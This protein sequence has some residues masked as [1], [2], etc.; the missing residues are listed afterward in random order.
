M[1]NVETYIVG[2]REMKPF[3]VFK[4]QFIYSNRRPLKSYKGEVLTS[5]IMDDHSSGSN[6]VYQNNA[7]HGIYSPVKQNQPWQN[8]R[9][10]KRTVLT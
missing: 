4:R 9:A 3:R 2:S 5:G 1:I 6:L 7:A 10:R 8:G